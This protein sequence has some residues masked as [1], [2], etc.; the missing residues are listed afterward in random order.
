MSGTSQQTQKEDPNTPNRNGSQDSRVG[1]GEDFGDMVLNGAA[2]DVSLV[3]SG[4]YMKQC[5]TNTTTAA[6]TEGTRKA[7]G[8]GQR[9][10]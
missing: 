5:M 8:S 10:Q 4:R 7:N 1:N 2:I 9:G 3:K 6:E